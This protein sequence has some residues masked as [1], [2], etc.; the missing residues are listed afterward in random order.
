MCMYFNFLS[1]STL[2]DNSALPTCDTKQTSLPAHAHDTAVQTTLATRCHNRVIKN[3]R[4]AT[5]LTACYLPRLFYYGERMRDL[6]P[7]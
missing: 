1:V 5:F 2:E 4:P 6:Q 7:Q 3:M